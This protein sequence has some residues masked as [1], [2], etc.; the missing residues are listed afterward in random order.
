MTS[1]QEYNIIT[2]NVKG[3][4]SP[5]KRKKSC[6]EKG[7]GKSSH[8]ILVRDAYK[9]EH[10]KMKQLGF[11]HTY[12]SS[13]KQRHARGVAI[14]MS[15]KKTFQLIKQIADKEWLYI[16]VTGLVDHKPVRLL[17]VYRPP[18]NDQMLIK[19]IFNMITE[20]TRGTLMYGRDWNILLQP[21]VDS[22][23]TT[24]RMNLKTCTVKKLLQEAKS[25]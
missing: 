11:R 10:E 23:N 20:E 6:N 15:N 24:K 18:G 22:T 2:L 17:N 19:K 8:N 16:L 13:Y 21:S 5:V 9:K 14:L 1:F 12:Y 4:Q 3:L 7:N 25:L